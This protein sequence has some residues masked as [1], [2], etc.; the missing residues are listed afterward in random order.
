MVFKEKSVK[1]R[2]Y[3]DL[4]A[5]TKIFSF[6]FLLAR[7]EEVYGSSELDTDWAD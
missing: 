1:T 5:F 6:I 3:T 7:L 4:I 2:D